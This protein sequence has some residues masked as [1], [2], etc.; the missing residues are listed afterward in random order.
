MSGAGVDGGDDAG[1]SVADA[2]VDGGSGVD[3]SFP[4]SNTGT[5]Y[6]PAGVDVDGGGADVDVGVLSSLLSDSGS[7]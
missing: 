2:D 7:P 4:D 6:S 1:A 3:S 5:P